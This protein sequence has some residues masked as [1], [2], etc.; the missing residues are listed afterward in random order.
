MTLLIALSVIA[1][2]ADGD[3]KIPWEVRWLWEKTIHRLKQVA[4]FQG[5][6]HAALKETVPCKGYEA[7]FIVV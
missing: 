3:W 6:T 5:M 1:A 4:V 2:D 7:Q